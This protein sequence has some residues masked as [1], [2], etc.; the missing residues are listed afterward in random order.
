MLR[1]FRAD[2]A[3]SCPI[4]AA[5]GLALTWD[6]FVLDRAVAPI[7][8]VWDNLAVRNK[9]TGARPSEILA[10][11]S[12]R[13]VRLLGEIAQQKEP[14][15]ELIAASMIEAYQAEIAEYSRIADRALMEDVRTVSAAVVRL[16]L[17]TMS[18]GQPLSQQE[19]IPLLQGAR[20][21]AAQGIDL[22][23][24]LRAFR[25]GVRVMWRELLS[26]PEWRDRSLRAALPLVAELA[27]DFADRTNTEVAG[28]YIDE[29]GHVHREREHRRSALLNVILSGPAAEPVD[30]PAELG[31]PH[32]IAIVRTQGELTLEQL[33]RIGSALESAVKASLW[34]IRLRSVIGVVPLD[35][36]SD[37]RQLLR[38]L[39]GLLSFSGVLAVALGSDAR[40]PQDSQQSYLEA[41]DA[42]Q[43]GPVLL[44]QE[45]SV[46]DYQDLAPTI[47][48]YR[49]PEKARRFVETTLKPIHHLTQRSWVLPTLEAYVAR[50]GRLKETAALLGVHLSSLKYRI[51]ELGDAGDRLLADGDSAA[52]LL[53]ALRLRRLLEQQEQEP[54]ARL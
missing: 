23:S 50:Q 7:S 49:D 27:L 26:A 53:V 32:A 30:R 22:H 45:C 35:E 4:R 17:R 40:G 19:L 43:I 39:H 6:T 33:E 8:S 31:R 41:F 46:F 47:A 1:P 24:V 37:R 2:L 12:P 28:A 42:L 34:T 21:R 29:L 44:G 13:A 14:E 52:T 54:G 36:R 15:A 9:T 5:Y 25:I 38:T 3:G 48:L 16:W 18:T 20:R 11:A 51:R 10:G